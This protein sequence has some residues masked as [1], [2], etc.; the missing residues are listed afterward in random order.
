MTADATC[1]HCKRPITTASRGIAADGTVLCHTG[2]I[3]PRNDPPDCYRLV[4]IY[5]HAT[6]GTCCRDDVRPPWKRLR[7]VPGDF[8]GCSRGCRSGTHT[9]KWGDCEFGVRPSP[10]F[11][12]WRTFIAEDGHRSIGMASIPLLA[13]LP[14]VKHLTV[15]DQHRMLEEISGARDP[16]AAV[17]RWYLSTIPAQQEAGG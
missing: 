14:W 9:L 8:S 11:G 12:F 15:D 2:T 17:Q 4:T 13:V 6:D 5:Q 1:G 3:P 10:E 7:D 16:A